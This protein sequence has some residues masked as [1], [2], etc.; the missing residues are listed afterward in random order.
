MG[1]WGGVVCVLS[2]M[3]VVEGVPVWVV[4]VFRCVDD[5]CWCLL[6]TLLLF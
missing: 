5:V 6:C 4:C 1:V 2:V 3:R